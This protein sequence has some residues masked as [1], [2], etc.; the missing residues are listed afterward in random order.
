M[1]SLRKVC[2]ECGMPLAV[3]IA[4]CSYCDA[5]VG[6][7]FDETA[8][9]AAPLKEKRWGRVAQ[10]MD[11]H[12]RIEKAQDRANNSSVL[13]LSSFFPLLGLVL[14]LAAVFL[15]VRAARTLKALN[16]EDGIG[17]ATAG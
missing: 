1:N 15:G 4:R 14:G 8:L 11:D 16:T 13:A 12:Q 17:S 2:P 10:Q 7:L 5:L 9:Q 3:G 6:T